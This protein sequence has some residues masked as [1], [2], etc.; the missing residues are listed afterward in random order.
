MKNHE[1]VE[2]TETF[3]NMFSLIEC[4]FLKMATSP[5]TIYENISF[6]LLS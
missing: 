2:D 6:D 3:M 4:V 5:G 1:I